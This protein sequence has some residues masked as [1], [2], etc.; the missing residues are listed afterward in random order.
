MAKRI[1]TW[2]REAKER[3]YD[4]TGFFSLLKAVDLDPSSEQFLD[5]QQMVDGLVN[6]AVTKKLKR[7][8][9]A[10]RLYKEGGRLKLKPGETA[11]SNKADNKA[12]QLVAALN[13]IVRDQREDLK[14]A[15]EATPGTIKSLLRRISRV[16]PAFGREFMAVYDNAPRLRKLFKEG[17]LEG[18]REQF[19]EQRMGRAMAEYQ[20]LGMALPANT[21]RDEFE[22][23]QAAGLS[24]L[25]AANFVGKTGAFVAAA[26]LRRSLAQYDEA[27]EILSERSQA[28]YDE[29]TEQRRLSRQRDL[30]GKTKAELKAEAK[31]LD[32]P[33]KSKTTKAQLVEAII[34]ASSYDAALDIS[35]RFT[36]E[37]LGE[38]AASRQRA[39]AKKRAERFRDDYLGPKTARR[40]KRRFEAE[41]CLVGIP[42]NDEDLKASMLPDY[43]RW[44]EK[45]GGDPGV[46]A[47]PNVKKSRE[48]RAL[49]SAD[50]DA[51]LFKDWIYPYEYM[52]RAE[53]GFDAA[54]RSSAAVEALGPREPIS[55]WP[56]QARRLWEFERKNLS[57]E[58]R[59]QSEVDWSALAQSMERWHSQTDEGDIRESVR[60][61]ARDISK[62]R[63]SG[64]P[65]L[66]NRAER[67]EELLQLTEE[68]LESFTE[69]RFEVR[70]VQR[71]LGYITI[72]DTQTG[73]PIS[74]AVPGNLIAEQDVL[75]QYKS[76]L[77]REE[78]LEQLTTGEL[79]DVATRLGAFSSPYEYMLAGRVR[80]KLESLIA[81]RFT[82][83]KTWDERLK[84]W[85]RSPRAW[86]SKAIADAAYRYTRLKGGQVITLSQGE[87]AK[88]GR[89]ELEDLA[90]LLNILKS[91]ERTTGSGVDVPGDNEFKSRVAAQ[92]D[93]PSTLDG[94]IARNLGESIYCAKNAPQQRGNAERYILYLN[95]ETARMLSTLLKDY[96]DYPLAELEAGIKPLFPGM[97]PADIQ[98]LRDRPKL[99][100]RERSWLR[101]WEAASDERRSLSLRATALLMNLDR[102]LQEVDQP[103][104]SKVSLD[105]PEY[106]A[107]RRALRQ[108]ESRLAKE[109]LEGMDAVSLAKGCL[110]R[111]LKRNED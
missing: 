102:A 108:D 8:S 2:Q 101:R 31:L 34:V 69:P 85:K 76:E 26:S 9:T 43:L 72:L 53:V 75:A 6:L 73:E 57:L 96:G 106:V 14:R 5:S 81:A 32:I 66:V 56:E 3:G 28:L 39:L 7:P 88:L 105:G 33:V 1:P 10:K 37:E 65:T 21:I 46:T 64:N 97:T 12:V 35:E 87:L 4:N 111:Y 54:S 42:A 22:L 52:L 62:M 74:E 60:V 83:D 71:P 95:G 89:T 24:P 27:L 100:A 51:E 58:Q 90:V 103:E 18:L 40:G 67:H 20:G 92:R 55:L 107:T 86:G 13:K 79:K 109:I 45:A 48:A 47:S 25:T 104:G 98:Q 99:S 23:L 68:W 80:N 38:L 29:I 82:G 50:V 93:V 44:R 15:H 61:W 110:A 30:E 91:K 49:I 78:L 41:G 19:T 70:K 94:R 84:R 36:A 77:A 11:R 16:D 63:E 59:A 17:I